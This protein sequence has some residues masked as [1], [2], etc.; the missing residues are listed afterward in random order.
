VLGG[1][2]KPRIIHVPRCAAPTAARGTGAGKPLAAA[3]ARWPAFTW[4]RTATESSAGFGALATRLTRVPELVVVRFKAPTFPDTYDSR[5]PISGHEQVRYWSICEYELSTGRLAG[6][7]ADYQARLDAHGYATI[8]LG[9]A[10]QRSRVAGAP[11]SANWLPF[12]GDRQG[13]LIYRQLLSAPGFMQSVV[14]AGSTPAVLQAHMGPYY[15]L[16]MRCSIV[17][18]VAGRCATG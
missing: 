17:R 6:C 7:V 4:H 9:S 2:Q 3:M 15:P 12:G 18:W 10:S 5:A 1:G 8:V 13:A 16:V 11:R 14:R